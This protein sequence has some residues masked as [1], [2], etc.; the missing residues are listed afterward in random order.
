MTLISLHLPKTAGAS[1]GWALNDFF[2]GSLLRD[3]DD[4]PMSK[5]AD[6][7]NPAALIAGEQL[8]T[9][10]LAGVSCV[11]GHFL[12]V[13]YLG[14][15]TVQNLRFVTWMRDPVQRLIS[16][17]NF[18]QRGYNR[19]TAGPHRKQVVEEKWTLEQFCLSAGFRNIY[20]QYLWA[21]PV[22]KFEFIGITDYYDDDLAYVAE[23]FLGGTLKRKRLNVTR[24]R[25]ASY[26][27]EPALREKIERYHSQDVALYQRALELRLARRPCR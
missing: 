2:G 20:S 14:L 7:R 17:Y 22:Q 27:I 26:S 10:G 4:R 1:F 16:H 6:E 3:Y 8:T 12:P 19:K 15:S 18:W 23:N 24:K 13:K 9:Q 25:T 11:H 21:F 5:P